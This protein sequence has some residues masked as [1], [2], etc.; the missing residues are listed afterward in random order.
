MRAVIFLL[1]PTFPNI[2]A[3]S[4]LILIFGIINSFPMPL[5]TSVLSL[6]ADDLRSV[7]N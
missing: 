7:L 2:V 4:L 5:I 6:L 3:F 1:L